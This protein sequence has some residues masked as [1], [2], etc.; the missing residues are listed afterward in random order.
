MKITRYGEN[1]VQ[2]TK[3]PLLFPIN[4]YLVREEDGLTLVD[5]GMKGMG[6]KIIE[7]AQEVTGQPIVRIA[8]THAHS[9]HVG[10]VDEL[11][12]LLAEAEVLV[13]DRDARFLR[14]DQSLD[15]DEPQSKLRG[16][17]TTIDTQPTR[18]LMPGERVGSLE[19]IAAPGHTPGQVAFFDTRDRTLIAGDAFQTRGGVAVSGTLKPLFP[20]PAMATWHKPT[21]LES[22]RRLRNL[23]PALL[24][25]G[26]GKAVPAPISVIEG[27]IADAEHS[28]GREASHA[29]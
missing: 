6:R 20:F 14:G 26:H 11:H 16:G 21:A 10:A 15:P 28:L 25:V 13:S 3:W 24:V 23:E 19:V 7:A 5:A 2:I 18:L 4:V 22:A 12:D 17:Y 29:S 9:D 8:L 1:L 27:A